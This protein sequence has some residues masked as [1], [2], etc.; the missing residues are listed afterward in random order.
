VY[1][2]MLAK[3]KA[4]EKL[5]IGE[6]ADQKRLYAEYIKPELESVGG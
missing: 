5:N 4:D 6:A 3:A 2:R 1:E